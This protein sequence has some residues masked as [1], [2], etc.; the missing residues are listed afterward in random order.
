MLLNQKT[1]SEGKGWVDGSLIGFKGIFPKNLKN[2]LKIIPKERRLR[3]MGEEKVQKIDR[4]FSEKYGRA[5]K[6]RLNS[7]LNLNEKE[8]T[9]RIPSN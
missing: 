6:I 2:Y 1:L 5:F 4:S 3:E 7:F 9:F 8:V